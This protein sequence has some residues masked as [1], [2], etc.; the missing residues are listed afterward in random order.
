MRVVARVIGAGSLLLLAGSAFAADANR[1]QQI[2]VNGNGKGA[3]ACASCHGADG[4][5]NGPAGFPRLAGLNSAYLSKQIDDFKAGTRNNSVMGP[6]ATALSAQ[7]AAD[8]AAYYAQSRTSTKTHQPSAGGAAL[9][10]GKRLAEIGDWNRGLPAC[11]SC[12][13]PGGRGV[14]EAFPRIA[15]QHASYISGQIKAW[16]EGGRHNDPVGLMKAVAQKLSDA[17]A[18]AVAA[19]F[20]GL[21]Q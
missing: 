15:G 11:V 21:E 4:A 10:R 9:G 16:R 14:G 17:D 1:G 13:G 3:V 6:I 5:G 2:A 19:Y 7:E 12:H 8:V 20:A 18:A